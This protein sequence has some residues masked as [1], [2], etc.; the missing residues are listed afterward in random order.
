MDI[1]VDSCRRLTHAWSALDD[2][3]DA[4]KTPEA[5]EAIDALYE[6]S[7]A[8][9]AIHEAKAKASAAFDAVKA[10]EDSEELKK[11]RLF[12]AMNTTAEDARAMRDR[13]SNI[14]LDIAKVVEA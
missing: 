7:L 10:V 12:L 1:R 2:F 5:L 9:V 3:E 13:L 14:A 11:V 8:I 4:P 6:L